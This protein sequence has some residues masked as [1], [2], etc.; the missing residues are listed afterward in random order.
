MDKRITG[1][2]LILTLNGL[3]IEVFSW[4]QQ[5]WICGDHAFNVIMELLNNSVKFPP[6]DAFP[7]L[8]C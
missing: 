4:S 3:L 2:S 1:N 7:S 8:F 5:T 6:Q